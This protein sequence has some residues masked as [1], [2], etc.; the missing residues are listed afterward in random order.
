MDRLNTLDLKLVVKIKAKSAE[1]NIHQ[2]HQDVIV[3]VLLN[4]MSVD[5]SFSLPLKS[6]QKLFKPAQSINAVASSITG[7]RSR[8]RRVFMVVG[9]REVCQGDFV[10]TLMIK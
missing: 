4:L 2:A 9:L 6:G 3:L 8:S 10:L 7:A 1:V 5:S